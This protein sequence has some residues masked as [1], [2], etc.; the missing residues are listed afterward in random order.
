MGN[1]T[2]G[3]DVTFCQHPHGERG[4]KKKDNRKGKK[5]CKKKGKKIKGKK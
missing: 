4:E 2:E 5:Q 3:H 1:D